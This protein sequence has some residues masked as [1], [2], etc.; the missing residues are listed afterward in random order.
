MKKSFQQLFIHLYT[1]V[2]FVKIY[3][4]LTS[5]MTT[6]LNSSID[7]F[8]QHHLDIHQK[9]S[10]QWIQSVID[11]PAY[12]YSWYEQLRI[13]PDMIITHPE[14]YWDFD[15]WSLNPNITWEFVN[16]HPEKPWNYDNLN[17]MFNNKDAYFMKMLRPE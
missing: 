6:T 2:N 3:N 10:R 13:S 9:W 4:N 1:W 11:S 7:S 15:A 17:K 8:T 5:T 14:M 12:R 16:E